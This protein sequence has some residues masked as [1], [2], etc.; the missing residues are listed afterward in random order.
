MARYVVELRKAETNEV[1]AL[2]DV[3]SDIENEDGNVDVWIAPA[4][5]E[6]P[7]D[8]LDQMVAREIGFTERKAE[9]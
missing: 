7:E 3:E 5:P 2:W 6:A 9:E 8:N 4:P 1:I